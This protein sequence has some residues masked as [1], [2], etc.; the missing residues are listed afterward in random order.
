VHKGHEHTEEYYPAVSNQ[1]PSET[2]APRETGEWVDTCSH[3]IS[4]RNAQREIRL[5]MNELLG[6]EHDKAAPN[7]PPPPQDDFDLYED[8][9]IGPGPSIRV[10]TRLVVVYL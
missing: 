2:A 5:T 8:D 6:I 9:G 4:N 7:I 10:T 1:H 3:L